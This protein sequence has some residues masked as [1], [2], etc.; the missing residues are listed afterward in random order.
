MCCRV[1]VRLTKQIVHFELVTQGKGKT[2]AI[3]KTDIPTQCA[4]CFTG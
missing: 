4:F 3:F 1:H 2:R